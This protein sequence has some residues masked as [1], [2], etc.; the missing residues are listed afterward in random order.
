MVLGGK[1]LFLPAFSDT[2]AV[3]LVPGFR[4]CRL[5][6]AIDSRFAMRYIDA[7]APMLLTRPMAFL[8]HGGDPALAWASDGAMAVGPWLPLSDD[9]SY[10]LESNAGNQLF[11]APELDV[12]ATVS[13]LSRFMT[14]QMG[15]IL[16]P[17]TTPPAVSV[18]PGVTITATVNGNPEQLKVKIK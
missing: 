6:K 5:G 3:S 12:S 17:V 14:L 15:D 4:L 2:W 8:E 11:T 13:A 9:G 7:V 1:P 18:K 16:V 10:S